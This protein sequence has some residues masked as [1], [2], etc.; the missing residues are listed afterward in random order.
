MAKLSYS[1]FITHGVLVQSDTELTD[2][3]LATMAVDILMTREK[4]QLIGSSD[5]EIDKW[6]SEES[7]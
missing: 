2:D 7:N 4:E 5:F 1:V 6:E 3:Q